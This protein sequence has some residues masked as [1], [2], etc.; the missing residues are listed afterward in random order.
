IVSDDYFLDL[1][2]YESIIKVI[3]GLVGG[4]P[5]QMREELVNISHWI[6]SI[7]DKWA[8]GY[9]YNFY[10]ISNLQS[11]EMNDAEDCFKK[12]Y[13]FFGVAND[14]RGVT[15]VGA[16]LGTSLIAKG[17]RAEGRKYIEDVIEG[18]IQLKNYSLAI[19]NLLQVSKS[20]LDDKNISQAKSLVLKAEELS[21]K[22]NITEPATFS[23]FCYFYSRI[24]DHD[25]A[26]NHLNKL[27]QI[28]DKQKSEGS[29]EDIYTS[30]WYINAASV[31]EMSK[32]NLYQA[33][34]LT[35]EG[36]AKADR[37]G[38]F[39]SS[40]ELS[41]L[42]T[43]ITLKRVLVEQ[44]E[45][46]IHNALE[47]L[48]DITPLIKRM[49][50]IYYE[51]IF[52]ILRAYLF[53]AL[54]NSLEATTLIEQTLQLSSEN[55]GSDQYA[56]ISLFN[57]RES[58]LKQKGNTIENQ[59]LF[60]ELKNSWLSKSN[61]HIIYVM[62]SLRLLSNLQFQ[63]NQLAPSDES[64]LPQF[65]FLLGT[66]GMTVYSHKFKKEGG[67][68]EVLIGGFLSALTS[69][70]QELFGGGML[71]RID[72]ENHVLLLDKITPSLILVLL[73]DEETYTLRKRFKKFSQLLKESELIGILD[74]DFYL[75]EDNP[76]WGA[77]DELV[78]ETFS[79]SE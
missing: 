15:T 59:N 26:D 55:T 47:L 53:L 17:E 52:N 36:I 33:N 65:L 22:A 39:D 2:F 76:Y 20:Y 41:T 16:N 46:F 27:R 79:G 50:N 54:G 77:L 49:E 71:T 75:S 66:G 18:M 25:Q 78:N 64:T 42:L 32:G 70:S 73:V 28:L 3:K 7:H 23:Y 69:F 11:Q 40:L 9:Y 29:A 24:G 13:E 48:N 34:E 51:S 45:R 72:Q 37:H 58:F 10:G 68:D 6:D 38:H 74:S 62:E 1:I 63:Q 12:A 30:I 21:S 67:F 56:E 60:A 31:N 4:Q 61:L 35:R 43:E 44:D 14:L 57:Q 8:K 5:K 19:S